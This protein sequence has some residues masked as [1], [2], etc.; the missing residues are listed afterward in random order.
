MDV[1]IAEIAGKDSIAAVLKFARGH[2]NVTIV[3]TVV[4]TGTEYGDMNSYK[5][6]MGFLEEKL[7]EVNVSLERPIYLQDGHLWNLLNAKYQYL[8]CRKF[9]F[10]S[11]CIGCHFYAHLLR[12]SVY[13]KYNAKGLITGERKSHSGIQKANQHEITLQAFRKIFAMCGIHMICP[14]EE[15]NDTN[16]VN[17]YIG[18]EAVICHANDVKCVISGNLTGF[19]MNNQ[20]NLM[21]LENFIEEYV[22]PVGM[23][24]LNN[25]EKENAAWREKLESIIKEIVI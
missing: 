21:N 25:Y 11:P 19:S 8:L 3:P 14:L 13:K 2:K 10:F 15:I 4:L 7:A 9:H 24:A 17:S 20:E 22:V 16:L 1:Y 6:S 23:F 5:R 18:N 12:V